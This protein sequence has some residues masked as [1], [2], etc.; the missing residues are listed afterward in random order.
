MQI[1]FAIKISNLINFC[2]NLFKIANSPILK[3]FL[4]TIFIANLLPI[5]FRNLFFLTLKKYFFKT[6]YM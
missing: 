2:K 1:F 6:L 5:S 3:V 4:S